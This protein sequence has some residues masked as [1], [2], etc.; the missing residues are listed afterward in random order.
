MARLC[1]QAKV[2]GGDAWR[3]GGLLG[4]RSLVLSCI[5][6]RTWRHVDNDLLSTVSKLMSGY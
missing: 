2:F 6:L 4:Q 3:R 5:E 1:A